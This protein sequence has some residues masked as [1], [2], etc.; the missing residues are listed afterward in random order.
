[1]SSSNN[2]GQQQK[3]IEIRRLREELNIV[4]SSPSWRMTAPCRWIFAKI[5]KKRA[6][7]R[8]WMSDKR[9]P[10]RR[11]Y[12]TLP[13][14]INLKT[15]LA[16]TIDKKLGNRNIEVKGRYEELVNKAHTLLKQIKERKS[17][18]IIEFP[19]VVDP[20]VSIIIP[21]Y[22][23]IEYILTCLVSIY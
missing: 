14:P 3:D 17:F 12:F 15:K 7:I 16:D 9:A 1:M 20:K 19:P 8:E 18:R 4:L 11:I 13:L 21:V 10:L 6:M 5:S 2:S 23:K 22:N